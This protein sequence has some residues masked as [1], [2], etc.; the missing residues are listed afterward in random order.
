MADFFFR[1]GMTLEGEAKAKF[2]LFFFRFLGSLFDVQ[3][4]FDP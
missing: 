3:L 1:P 4:F 2:G